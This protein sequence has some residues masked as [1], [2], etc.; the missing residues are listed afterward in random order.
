METRE[1]LQEIV[2]KMEEKYHHMIE[3]SQLTGQ[4]EETLHHNDE[5]S[6]I[7]VMTMRA[8]E[9]DSISTLD[10]QMQELI[11]TLDD[12]TQRSI[13]DPQASEKISSE[14]R[15]YHE[16]R[17]KIHRIVEQTIKKDRIMSEKIAGAASFY[18]K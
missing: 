2:K 12:A 10:Q 11:H 8:Q 7:M 6:I 1:T 5:Q 18:V 13:K 15:R 17:E 9:M 4:L 16:M 14:I 3:V